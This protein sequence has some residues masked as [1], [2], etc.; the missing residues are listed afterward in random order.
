ME[1]LKGLQDVIS[2]APDKLFIIVIDNKR[3]KIYS[4]PTA[5]DKVGVSQLMDDIENW[6]ERNKIRMKSKKGLFR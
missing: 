3:N 5:T 6:V 1:G 4:L 2:E